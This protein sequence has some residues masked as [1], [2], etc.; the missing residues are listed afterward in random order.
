MNKRISIILTFFVL[1]ISCAINTTAQDII[2]MKNGDEIEAHIKSISQSEVSYFRHDAPQG[3]L[4]S[5]PVTDIFMIK[6]QNGTKDMFGNQ[7]AGYNYDYP[8][9]ETSKTYSVGDWFDES[10]ISGIVIY[11][12]DSGTHGL[13]MYPKNLHVTSNNPKD[14]S[15]SRE[16]G[17]FGAISYDDGYLN[18]LAL[19]QWAETNDKD[20]D[21]TFPQ[22]SYVKILGPG[23]YIPAA[24]EVFHIALAFNGGQIV[25]ADKEARKRFNNTLKSHGGKKLDSG[26]R[27]TSSSEYSYGEYI[28]VDMEHGTFSTPQKIHGLFTISGYT[29]PVHKF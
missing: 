15:Y 17:N 5:L 28:C 18:L 11:V 1:T 20:Y 14:T 23:W 16:Y 12:D 2:I 4:Y 26:N 6:Y 27:I 3:P 13:V 19:R 22:A 9:P 25:K 29:R 21:Y 8:Y 7:P 10:G 24:N